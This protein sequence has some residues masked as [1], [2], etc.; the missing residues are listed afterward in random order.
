M[1]MKSSIVTVLALWWCVSLCSA[2]SPQDVIETPTTQLYAPQEYGF[3]LFMYNEGGMI[4]GF[5]FGLIRGLNVGLSMDF[6]K[7]ISKQN[8]KT[9]PPKLNTKVA[10]YSGGKY[11][12]AMALGYDGQG[13][14]EY[15]NGN[16]VQREKGLYFVFGR[17]LFLEDWIW[18]AGVNMYDFE[19]TELYGFANTSYFFA[20]HCTVLLECANIHRTPENRWNIGFRY[21]LNKYLNMSISLKRINDFDNGFERTFSICY[22]G[23]LNMR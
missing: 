22:R 15:I 7:A 2:Q 5:T 4:T 6:Y 17:E 10:V 18:E 9:R 21:D 12:P 3:N 14:G 13:Y 8:M 16:Y 23:K 1:K 20:R 11:F 19:N